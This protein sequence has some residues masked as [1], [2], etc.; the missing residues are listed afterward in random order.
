M[1]SRKHLRLVRV[2]PGGDVGSSAPPAGSAIADAAGAR[3]ED[4]AQGPIALEDAFRI[5]APIVFRV[6]HR[7]LGSRDEAQDLV[8]DVFVKAQS[9]LNRIDDP[10]ALRSWLITVTTREARFRLRLRRLRSFLGLRRAFDYESVAG[11]GASPAQRVLTAE[12]YAMLE[13][14]PVDARVAWT[15]RYVEGLTLPE[16]AHHC[17]CSL[18]TVKR[19]VASVQA[20]ILEGIGDD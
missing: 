20:L 10:G 15:L 19:R 11:S 14:L 12:I 16:V 6:A 2:E 4:R 7:V 17:G 1:Q 3:G 8:Q 9:W 13:H 5:Y 18:A